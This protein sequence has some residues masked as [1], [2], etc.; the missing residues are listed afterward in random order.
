[1]AQLKRIGVLSSAKLQAILMAY[2]GLIAGIL[3]SFG[4]AIY[5]VVTTGSVNWGTALAFFALIGMPIV[6]ATFGFMTGVIGASLNNLV[7]RWVGGS[8][9]GT[10]WR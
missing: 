5:D 3:Y 9:G 4:G 1:M 8:H 10:A 2:V 6:F 7:A